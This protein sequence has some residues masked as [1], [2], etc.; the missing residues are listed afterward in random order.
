M[1]GVPVADRLEVCELLYRYA[2]AVDDT[3]WQV[4]ADEVFTADAVYD[5]EDVG[6]GVVHGASRIVTV[7]ARIRHPVA[8]HVLAPI[9]ASTGDRDR[10]TVRSRWLVVLADRTALAGRYR[11][12]VVRTPAGWR[13]AARRLTTLQK[14]SS[15][16]VPP[17]A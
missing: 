16:I 14:G 17:D 6:L 13:I 7:F 2:D 1:I 5:L 12:T 4:L 10:L 11:D 9:V 15:R 8:H 3:A